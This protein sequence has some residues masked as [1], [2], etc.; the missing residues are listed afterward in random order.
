[1]PDPDARA[2]Q[3][4]LL[5]EWSRWM[6]ALESAVCALLWEP[7]MLLLLGFVFRRAAEQSLS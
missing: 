5:A 2:R 3:V 1:M 6:V 7:L 4:E